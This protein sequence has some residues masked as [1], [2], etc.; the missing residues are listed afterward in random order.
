MAGRVKRPLGD[1][2]GLTSS[3]V[4]PTRP[5]P[6]AVAAL[7]HRHLRQDESIHVLEGEPTLFTDAG[8]TPNG[9]AT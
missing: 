7:H 1:P 9:G 3:G 8:E 2:F 6:G 5:P 4:N